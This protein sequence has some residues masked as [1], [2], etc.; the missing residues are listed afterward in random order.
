MPTNTLGLTIDPEFQN[1][2]PSMTADELDGLEKLINK[3]AFTHP[4]IFW[5]LNGEKVIVDGHNRFDIWLNLPDDTTIQP[6]TLE[7]MEFDDRLDVKIWM[8]E[9]QDARRNWTSSQRKNMIGAKHNLIKMKQG[10]P[11]GNQNASI[12]NQKNNVVKPTT[13]FS[14]GSTTKPKLKK[15]ARKQVA[16]DHGETENYVRDAAKYN[17]AMEAIKEV[18]QKAH[19]CIT[20]GK[21]PL[22]EKE[23]LAIAKSGKILEALSNLRKG[24]K[25]N[26]SIEFEPVPDI[27][28]EDAAH[29]RDI[30]SAT[31]KLVGLMCT[32]DATIDKLFIA[33][34]QKKKT[35]PEFATHH[36][37]F[38]TLIRGF[39]WVEPMTEHAKKIEASWKI[40]KKKCDDW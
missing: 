10:A 30:D 18:N 1:L 36:K 34:D 20:S 37:N 38:A 25:W 33:I 19:A 29:S 39:K 6:P 15:S 17:T 9:N 3:N 23:V 16:E 31:A 12:S 27:K 26:D 2:L 14:D 35:S 32:F 21:L 40:A 7:R 4:I 8:I 24:R 5:Q 28:K 22:S 13:L 11:E